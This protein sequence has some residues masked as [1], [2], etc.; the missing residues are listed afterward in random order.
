MKKSRVVILW[1][2]R[3]RCLCEREADAEE[4]KLL[5]I[6]IIHHARPRQSTSVSHRD[7]DQV[8]LLAQGGGGEWVRRKEV[9]IYR[10]I[11]R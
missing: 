10:Q 2:W 4:E 6:L 8:S 3:W 11:G 9:L 5:D 7:K 1:S